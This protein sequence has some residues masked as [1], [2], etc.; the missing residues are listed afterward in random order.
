MKM[1]RTRQR[2]TPSTTFFYGLLIFLSVIVLA[3]SAAAQVTV[4]GIVGT[5][6]DETGGVLPGVT[7]TVTGPAL[8]VPQGIAVT[9]AQGQYRVAPLPV[10]TFAVTYELSGFQ[11]VKRE[12][13]QLQVGFVAKLDQS[14]RPGTVQETVT[15]SGESPTVDVTNP[16]H[17]VNI[18]NDAVELLPT[19]RDGLKAYIGQVPGIRT[20]LDVGASSMTDTVQIR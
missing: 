1:S 9:D 13:V 12:G 11:T 7:V 20:N 16:A 14:L 4:A 8:Q 2:R 15:V 6:T 18:S 5:I 19:N 17:S 3:R 10:G